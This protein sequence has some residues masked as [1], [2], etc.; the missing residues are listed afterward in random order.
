M[1]TQAENVAP[2]VLEKRVPHRSVR[3][4]DYITYNA[5]CDPKN[6]HTPS[7]PHVPSMS[8]PMVQGNSSYP[9]T[10][11]VTDALFSEKHQVF[12]AAISSGVEPHSFKEAILDERWNKVMSGE[13][14]ALELN[15]TWELETLPEGNKA[16]GSKWVYKLKFNADGT[17]DI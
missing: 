5:R 14:G 4:K 12:L 16:I 13:I 8:S 7:V 15:K 9:I 1:Q 2:P 3:L 17:T 11:Y 10:S 6:K